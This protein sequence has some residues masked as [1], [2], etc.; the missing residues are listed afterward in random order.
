MRLE[1]RRQNCLLKNGMSGFR[2]SDLKP[3]VTLG[4]VGLHMKVAEQAN[5]AMWKLY[6]PFSST[7]SQDVWNASRSVVA[8]PS[9]ILLDRL[10]MRVHQRGSEAHGRFRRGAV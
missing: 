1:L 2:S 5:G 3:V 4:D 8:M 9:R 7:E 6:A 10:R